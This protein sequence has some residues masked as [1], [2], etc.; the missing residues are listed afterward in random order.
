MKAGFYKCYSKEDFILNLLISIVVLTIL[1]VFI[2]SYLDF[3]LKFACIMPV[4]FFAI[5]Y[6]SNTIKYYR[7]RS[8]S[9]QIDNNKIVVSSSKTSTEIF[10]DEIEDVKIVY[11]DTIVILLLKSKKKIVLPSCSEKQNKKVFNDITLKINLIKASRNE[12]IKNK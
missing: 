2:L 10:F 11:F 1:M 3:I 4:L 7:K 8:V 12:H 6:I 9:I 5:I